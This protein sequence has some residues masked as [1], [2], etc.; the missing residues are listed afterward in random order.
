MTEV[1]R[2]QKLADRLD[3]S[4]H[5]IRKSWKQLPHFFVSN[6]RD[7]RSARFDVE[8]VIN[9]LKHNDILE[10]DDSSVEGD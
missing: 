7:L 6:G 1:V 2:Y 10:E 3:C 9:F 4:P 8:E 5:V